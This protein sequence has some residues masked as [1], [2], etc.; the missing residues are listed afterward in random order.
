[1]DS[2]WPKSADRHDRHRLYSYLKTRFGIPVQTFDGYLLFKRKKSW[3]LIRDTPL[4]EQ[5]SH[6]KV[7]II[8]MRAFNQIQEF[9]KPTTKLIQVFGRLAT[10]GVYSIDNVQLNLLLNG[11]TLPGLTDDEDGYIILSFKNQPI[12][13][14]LLI[15]GTIRSQLPRKDFLFIR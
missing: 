10:K 8:G 4:V 6:L 2:S 11:K 15:K 14:G 3:W 9:V 1:L 12:G 13:L 7:S 5:I